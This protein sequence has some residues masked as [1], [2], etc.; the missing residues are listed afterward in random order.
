MVNKITE[1]SISNLNI[2]IIKQQSNMTNSIKKVERNHQVILKF[3]NIKYILVHKTL[4][5]FDIIFFQT[6]HINCL[7]AHM[8]QF[9]HSFWKIKIKI[10][11]KESFCLFPNAYILHSN[12]SIPT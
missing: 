6:S 4:E 8:L 5:S 2:F 10:K 1:L 3:F 11:I 7:Y 9:Q 12:Q